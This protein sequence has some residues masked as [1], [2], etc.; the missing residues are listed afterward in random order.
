MR[1]LARKE[2]VRCRKHTHGH[3]VLFKPCLI[4][5]LGGHRRSGVPLVLAAI[6]IPAHEGRDTDLDQVVKYQAQ[7]EDRAQ[8]HAELIH[9][10]SLP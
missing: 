6:A 5:N 3:V 1:T 2:S 9:A 10:V 7:D 4:G 8:L